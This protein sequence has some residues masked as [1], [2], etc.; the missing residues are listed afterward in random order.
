M[1]KSVRRD[2]RLFRLFLGKLLTFDTEPNFYRIDETKNR[3][4]NH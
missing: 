2:R 4:G 1:D 3:D